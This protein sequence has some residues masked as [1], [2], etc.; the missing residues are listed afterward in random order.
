MIDRPRPSPWLAIPAD[1]YE[2]HMRAVGQSGALRALFAKVYA[3]RRPARLAV[4]GCSTGAD[5]QRVDDSIT[6]STIGVDINPDYLVIA[7]ERLGHRLTGAAAGIRLVHG[8]VLQVALP[9][10]AFEL[11]HAALLL[12]Y[13]D[14]RA[15]FARVARW[16][17]PL[18]TFSVITQE[19]RDDLPA[20]SAT[21]YA[22]L[23]T[24]SGSMIL[25]SAPEVAALAGAAGFGLV[26]R[27]AIAL[28]TGKTL[29]ASCFRRATV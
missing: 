1:D 7:G 17:S 13:V 23:A 24:L 21:G 3:E 10:G 28:P 11:I 16:L 20:V 18:G 6:Q 5:L 29:V 19:P 25:R 9:T 22:T 14:P 27:D 2:A 12:E 8:D 4:L 26:G 15:L